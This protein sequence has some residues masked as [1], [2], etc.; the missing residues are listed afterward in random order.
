MSEKEHLVRYLRTSREAVLWKAEGLSERELRTP[1]TTTGTN[2]L[3][4]VKHCASVEL[5]YFSHCLGRESG[6][7]VPEVDLDTDPNG[8]LYAGADESAE[9]LVDLYRRV[10]DYVDATL[11][12]LPFDTPAHVPWWGEQA[13]TTV[14]RLVVH[15]LVD[16]ARHAGH[17]DILREGIDGAT[18]LRRESDNLVEP[19]GGWAAHRAKLQRLADEA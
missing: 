2:L 9:E 4:L 14:G 13:D 10:G 11:A 8:D 3:G 7:T 15:V 16:V 6:I 17:A 1:R 12:E 18:G 19:A 5:E